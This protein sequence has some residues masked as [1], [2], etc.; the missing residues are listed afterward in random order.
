M[1]KWIAIF[2]VP[3]KILSDNELVSKNGKRFNIELKISKL[4][5]HGALEFAKANNNF[6]ETEE[7]KEEVKKKKNTNMINKESLSATEKGKMGE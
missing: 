6:R 3:E 7:V 4:K 1:E 2:G 5:A